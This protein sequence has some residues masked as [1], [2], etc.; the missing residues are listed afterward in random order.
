[1]K[2]RNNT[3]ERNNTMKTTEWTV[4]DTTEAKYVGMI[5]FQTQDGEL[6]DFEVVK[7]TTRSKTPRRLVFGGSCNVGFIESGYMDMEDG[8]WTHEALS[9][10]LADLECYYNDGPQYV[11]RIICNER[12]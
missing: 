6:H 3:T 11:S 1:V 5:E 2:Q 7:T 10:M 9:E 4:S 8:E 12:M